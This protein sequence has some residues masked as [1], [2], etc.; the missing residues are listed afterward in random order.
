MFCQRYS[1]GRPKGSVAISIDFFSADDQTQ[2]NGTK[3]TRK[4]KTSTAYRPNSHPD[5]LNRCPTDRP[6]LGDIAIAQDSPRSRRRIKTNDATS[7]MTVITSERV[8]A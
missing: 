5:R 2:M 7:E 8:E 4:K 3:K 1:S 6:R